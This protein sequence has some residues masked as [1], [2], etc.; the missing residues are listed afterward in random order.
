MND[1]DDLLFGVD[2]LERWKRGEQPEGWLDQQGAALL[3]R[4]HA[5][6]AEFQSL[7]ISADPA[8]ARRLNKRL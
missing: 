6:L 1:D 7:L 2:D 4:C 5:Q 3:A 8:T